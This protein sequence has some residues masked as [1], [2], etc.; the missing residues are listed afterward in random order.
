MKTCTLGNAQLIFYS[1]SLKMVVNAD[2]PKF[3]Q[4]L[5]LALYIEMLF[6]PRFV[7]QGS[8]T[9]PSS[10]WPTQAFQRDKSWRETIFQIMV[11]RI[12]VSIRNVA[13]SYKCS[14][15]IIWRWIFSASN[16]GLLFNQPTFW[17]SNVKNRKCNAFLRYL[18]TNPI[19]VNQTIVIMQ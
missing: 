18:N 2:W 6:L 4:T 15:L 14:F 7:S 17:W 12:N 3:Y 8:F 5:A 19:F 10:Q 1:Q 16:Q 9:R 13:L 11:G